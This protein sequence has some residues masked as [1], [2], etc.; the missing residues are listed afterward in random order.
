[1]AARAMVVLYGFCLLTASCLVGADWLD[2]FSAACRARGGT[3]VHNPGGGGY[4]DMSRA[5]STG[6]GGGV[7]PYLP[8]VQNWLDGL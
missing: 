6:S 8:G 4:C 2:Q 1:M 7:N 3:P 5:G